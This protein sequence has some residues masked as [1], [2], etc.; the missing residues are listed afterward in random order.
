MIQQVNFTLL[1]GQVYQ[2]TFEIEAW[3]EGDLGLRLQLDGQDVTLVP[4]SSVEERSEDSE[5]F[6]NN[7]S[8][9][10]VFVNIYRRNFVVYRQLEKE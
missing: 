7:A 8:W 10:V 2:Y 1:A 3:K 9:S 6:T 5:Q 4:I